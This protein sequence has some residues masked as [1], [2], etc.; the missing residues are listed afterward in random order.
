VLKV[1]ELKVHGLAPLDF[2]LRKGD[3]LVVRGPSGSGKSL[4]LRAIADLDEAAGDVVLEGKNKKQLPAED[5]RKRVRYLAAES[6]WW[7]DRVEEHF[8]DPNT[9]RLLAGELDLAEKLFQSPVAQLSSGERQR[10][11][12][13]RAIEDNPAVLLLDEPT[14]ALDEGVAGLM[15]KKI[16]SLQNQGVI[17][18]IVTHSNAQAVRLATH[19]LT[20]MDGDTRFTSA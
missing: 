11:A 20:L 3:S 2:E 17:L 14:S 6:G 12:F 10:M 1:K 16:M 13:V 4:L 18:V 5:W 8:K 9:A 15:E 19:I 7:Y